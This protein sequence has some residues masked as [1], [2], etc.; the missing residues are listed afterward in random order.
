MLYCCIQGR[1]SAALPSQKA[2]TSATVVENS[3]MYLQELMD[4]KLYD[5]SKY[6]QGGYSALNIRSTTNANLY[7]EPVQVYRSI[8]K[9]QMTRGYPLIDYFLIA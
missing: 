2:V 4:S 1:P 7:K 3:T 9:Q 8:L 5:V 6:T